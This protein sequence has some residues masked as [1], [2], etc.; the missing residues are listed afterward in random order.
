ML[1]MDAKLMPRT[2]VLFD[3]DG[4]LLITGGASSRSI[5][6][7]AGKLLGDRFQWRPVTVGLLDPQIFLEL[8]SLCGIED[9]DRHLDAYKDLYLAELEAELPSAETYVK[10]LPGMRELVDELSKRP[11]V[12]VGLLTGNYRRAVELKLKAA[13]LD[14]DVFRVGAFA[15]DG[16]E[17]SDLV[18]VAIERA[19]HRGTGQIDDGRQVI[20]V[21]DTPRDISCAR[22]AGCRV[23]AVASGQYSVEQLAQHGPDRVVRDLS[24]PA[25]LYEMIEQVI[26]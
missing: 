9:A 4:T 6:R 8:A 2:L 16:R 20:L 19:G 7:A 11:D 25:P 17:R 13:G 23:L 21:G 18:A 22:Q 15:E 3:V 10:V 12:I 26:E 1:Q 24:D 5:R 14:K